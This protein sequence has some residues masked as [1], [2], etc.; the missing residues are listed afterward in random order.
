MADKPADRTAIVVG[1]GVGGLAAAI[2]LRHAGWAVTVL[3]RSPRLRESGAGWSFSPNAVRAATLL[4]VEH[5]LRAISVS[6]QAGGNLRRPDGTWLMRFRDGKDVV[7]LANHRREFVHMLTRHVPAES[8]R[9]A[10]DVVDIH[11]TPDE[12][13]VT[14]HAESGTEHISAALLVGADGIRSV[15]RSA[16]APGAAPVF[17]RM[18]C[19]RAVTEPGSCPGVVGFQTWGRGVRLGAHPLSQDRVFWFV[20]ARQPHPGPPSDDHEHDLRRLV[21]SW[22]APIPAL[23][24]ATRSDSL[25]FT[26]IDDLDPLPTFVHGRVALLGDAAHAMTP[27]LAQGACQALE[28]AVLLGKCADDADP[29]DA[30]AAYNRLRRPRSQRVARLARLDPRIS[31][32]TSPLMYT[33]MTTLTRTLGHAIADRKMKAVWTWSPD[34]TR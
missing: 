1:A 11:H 3:E 5:D 21:G 24:D 28:D 20:V 22:H 33:V 19:W 18:V 13:T 4:G 34:P 7:L 25:L 29:S 26:D 31:L 6:S 27:M 32:S 17:Q 2:A 14:V 9:T 8:I 23:L 10:A 16:V 15:A 30:L 12:V